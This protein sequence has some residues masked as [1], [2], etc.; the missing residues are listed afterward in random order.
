MKHEQQTSRL[1]KMSDFFGN[2][3]FS[4][5][6]LYNDHIR[7][8]KA[9][10]SNF[11]L[12]ELLVVIAII[13]ILASLLLPAM[14]SAREKGRSIVCVNNLK[15]MYSAAIQYT[16]DNNDMLPCSNIEVW[17]YIHFSVALI[18]YYGKVSS[19]ASVL[20]TQ[21]LSKFL[22]CPSEN[23]TRINAASKPYIGKPLI[24]NY[25]LTCVADDSVIAGRNR[26]GGA[27]LSKDGSWG[28]SKALKQVIPNSVI[29][30]EMYVSTFDT[31][32]FVQ[33]FTADPYLNPTSITYYYQN[34]SVAHEPYVPSY[35]HHRNSTFLFMEGNVKQLRVNDKFNNDWQLK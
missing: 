32:S 6:N 12:I 21:T 24:F 18:P 17:R 16:M 33:G 10:K 14:N 8:Y 25:M 31:S 3:N 30:A 5:L 35:I 26:W 22:T 13:A 28:K 34:G 1:E 2:S 20:Q 15:Q 11:T 27:R 7:G 4:R 29:V 23:F 9:I 19:S